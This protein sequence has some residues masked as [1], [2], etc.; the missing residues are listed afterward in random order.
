MKALKYSVS[1]LCTSPFSSATFPRSLKAVDSRVLPVP[2]KAYSRTNGLLSGFLLGF[3]DK[4][5]AQVLR[6]V[7]EDRRSW[8]RSS[9]LFLQAGKE[10]LQ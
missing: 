4:H 2:L 8:S 3:A 5:R 6:R 10:L 9:Q 7:R 1:R